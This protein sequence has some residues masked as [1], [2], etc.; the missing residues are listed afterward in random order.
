MKLSRFAVHHPV[1]TIMSVLIV[2]ILGG[3]SFSRLPID[4]MPD[5]TYP[6]LS[7]TTIYENASPEEI[8]ELVTR[9]V[10]EAVS[11]VPGVE[12]V[13]SVSAEGVSQVRTTFAW[14]G[15]T[16]LPHVFPTMQKD[17]PCEN[18]TWQ[19]FQSSFLVPQ[20]IWILSRCA[21]SLMTRSSIA[22]SN[23]LVWQQSMSR[24]VWTG[25]SM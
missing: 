1:F 24:G 22:L 2:M 15:W 8:E 7:I 23:C 12:E 13:T 25:K 20:A 16:G 17:P 21:G 4:L 3:I 14:A 11:A 18:T 9:P 10:E 6:T 19:A 5:I